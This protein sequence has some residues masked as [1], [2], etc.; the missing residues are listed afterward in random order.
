MSIFT[1]FNGKKGTAA[2]DGIDGMIPSA[3]NSETIENPLCSLMNVNQITNSTEITTTRTSDASYTD[4]YGRRSWAR[5]SVLNNLVTYSND[6]TQWLDTFSRWTRI[7]SAT[8]PFG[9]NL[10]T[11]INLDVD[12]SALGGTGGVVEIATTGILQSTQITLSVWVKVISGT[13]TGL[14]FTML[15]YSI[16]TVALAPTSDWQRIV[17]PTCAFFDVTTFGINPRGLTGARVALYGAQIE[18]GPTAGNY[19]ETTNTARTVDSGEYQ[20]RSSNLGLLLE[21][22]KTNLALESNDLEKWTKTNC[23]ITQFLGAD[24]FGHYSQNVSVVWGSL[25]DAELQND[26][27]TLTLA[28]EYSVS[29]YAWI[30]GGALTTFSVSLGGGAEV[31]LPIP[32]VTGWERITVKCTA[33]A[34]SNIRFK[35]NSP[36]LTAQLLLAN[37][38]IE[39]GDVTSYIFSC[40]FAQTRGGDVISFDYKYNFPTP[41][42]PWSILFNVENIPASTDNKY[43]FTNGSFST[44]EFSM[45]FKNN[46][47]LVKTNSV[48]HGTN[49]L[50]YKQIAVVYDGVNVNFYNETGLVESKAMTPA[51]R[52]GSTITIGSNIDT[53]LSNFRAFNSALSANDILYMQ[54]L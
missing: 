29:F 39:T 6:F 7:G 11:E 21:E 32:Q 31:S 54:G 53:Y 3:V 1:I 2:I 49:M 27:D 8:D 50:G 12:T 46:N 35:M 10:A 4:R 26:T 52:S 33:G 17:M 40:G 5:T 48:L 45:Y 28:V 41:D 24:P 20:A 44:A 30:E 13:V 38:Q 23:T 51:A 34:A 22:G 42:L 36:S 25:A 19:I 9:G 47:L 43:V 15:P 18:D 14:D 16:R 37:V